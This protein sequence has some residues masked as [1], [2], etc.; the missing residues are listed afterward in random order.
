MGYL[1]QHFNPTKVDQDL[2]KEEA[3][4]IAKLIAQHSKPELIVLIG[5][6]SEG[7]FGH[8]SDIDLV[9]VYPDELS[10]S[11]AKKRLAR[12]QIRPKLP[13]D[14][15]FCTRPHFEKQKQIGGPF[16]VAHNEGIVLYDKRETV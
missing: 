13:V 10:L 8:G 11:D 7:T 16:F 14:Y 4:R 12:A 5:S 2:A 6:L 1:A 15:L 3:R 9:I